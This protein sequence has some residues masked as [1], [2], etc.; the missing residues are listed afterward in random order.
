ML[1]NIS[2][3]IVTKIS[4]KGYPYNH[5]YLLN[6]I[7][8]FIT[9]VDKYQFNRRILKDKPTI[10]EEYENVKLDDK[11]KSFSGSKFSFDNTLGVLT[12]E[13]YNDKDFRSDLQI[14]EDLYDVVNWAY[15]TQQSYFEGKGFPFEH[16]DEFLGELRLEIRDLKLIQDYKARNENVLSALIQKIDSLEGIISILLD[17]VTTNEDKIESI[18]Y[19]INSYDD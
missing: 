9:C 6:S 17:R 10:C 8:T 18:S 1:N 15:E 3:K 4:D 19:E 7:T 5:V 2:K 13:R 14:L 12:I 16:F 11:I